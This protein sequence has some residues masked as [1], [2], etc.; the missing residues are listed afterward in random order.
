MELEY[1]QLPNLPANR[2]LIHLLLYLSI[3]RAAG[4]ELSLVIQRDLVD[5]A[6]VLQR[7][8]AT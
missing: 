7:Y 4:Q 5:L 2:I 8:I 3:I 6:R 1:L